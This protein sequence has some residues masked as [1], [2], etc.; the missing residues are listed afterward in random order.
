MERADFESESDLGPLEGSG[1]EHDRAG[2]RRTPEQTRGLRPMHPLL[3]AQWE[4]RA[5]RVAMS[6]RD[7]SRFEA[8]TRSVAAGSETSARAHGT[9]ISRLLDDA[10][11]PISAPLDW[12]DWERRKTIRLLGQAP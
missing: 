3:P 11:T 5:L 2:R 1:V 7:W 4:S 10:S 9:A 12:L 8:Y 6:R